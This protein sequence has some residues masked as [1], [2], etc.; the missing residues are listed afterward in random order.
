MI[1]SEALSE[2]KIHTKIAKIDIRNFAIITDLKTENASGNLENSERGQRQLKTRV[3][4]KRNSERL[5]NLVLK[6]LVLYFSK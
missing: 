3:K 2:A 1:S 4:Q 6:I 5:V